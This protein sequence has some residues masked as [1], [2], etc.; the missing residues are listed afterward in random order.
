MV[1]VNIVRNAVGGRKDQGALNESENGST[2]YNKT[3]LCHR[4]DARR[5]H[6]Y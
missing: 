3:T 2:G 5:C 6:I 1:A 4:G